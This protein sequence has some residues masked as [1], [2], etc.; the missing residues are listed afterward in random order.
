MIL[1]YNIVGERE[2]RNGNLQTKLKFEIGHLLVRKKMLFQVLFS[3]VIDLGPFAGF[4][5]LSRLF[6]FNLLM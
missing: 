2:L 1:Q 5:C 3:P 4:K 6:F